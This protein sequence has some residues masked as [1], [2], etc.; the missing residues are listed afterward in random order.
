MPF[1][2]T[3]LTALAFGLSTLIA[4]SVAAPQGCKAH[5][6]SP[7]KGGHHKGGKGGHGGAKPPPG[8]YD[9]FSS[10]HWPMPRK[11]TGQDLTS[12]PDAWH[13][14]HGGVHLHDPSVVLGPDGHYYSFSS[15][16]LGVTSRASEENSLDGDWEVVG[17]VLTAPGSID[18]PTDVPRL[19]APDVHRV[20]DTYY[21][22]Y[23]ISSFGVSDSFIGLATSQ[24]LQNGSW[25]DLGEVI[26]SGNG[27][28]V[29]YPLTITNAID[30]ALLHDPVT[31]TSYLTYGSWWA[32][33][34]QF[35][36]NEDMQ[37]VD[38]DSAVQLSYTFDGD[39]SKEEAFATFNQSWGG[40]SAEEG[41]YLSHN[42]E[43]GYYYLWYSAGTCCGYDPENL[44]PAGTEYSVRVGRSESP[45]G[46]FVDREGVDLAEGGGSL[47][48]GSRPGVYGPGGQAV[49]SNYRGRDV[50][51]YHYVDTEF[52][53][54]YN[55]LLKFLG[56]NFID[57]VEGWPVLTDE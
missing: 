3:S 30:A 56:W 23:T 12:D 47:V 41:A 34:W 42:E 37:S 49:L 33:I 35:I 19:W 10:A 14:G 45:R 36:L 8:H 18:D 17:Q 39:L 51:Y 29:E 20:G 32:N 38:M 13:D 11:I 6:D 5:Y 55:D 1:T 25:T 40:N 53:P 21:C 2:T 31:E 7:N 9:P 24:T 52:D 44:P 27:S 48:Y 50:L 46:P 4:P 22:Y 43:Q 16:G 15:H 28:T 26:R 57:Y 54:T